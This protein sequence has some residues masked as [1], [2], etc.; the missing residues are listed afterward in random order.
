M[1]RYLFLV[2][3]LAA[4]GM[5]S[6][7][8]LPLKAPPYQSVFSTP[9]GVG[10]YGG[11]ITEADVAQAH[12]NGTNLFATSLVGG[13]LNATGGAVGATGGYIGAFPNGWW[14]VHNDVV[15][16]NV[17][18]TNA[19]GATAT[20]SAASAFVAQRWAAT[21]GLDVSMEWLQAIYSRLPA[22][23]VANFP[24]FVPPTL[25][26]ITNV[27]YGT[28]RNYAGFMLKEAGI[29]G[30]FGAARGTTIAVYP[31]LETGFIWPTINSLTGK[32]DGGALE[33]SAYVA[34]PI[35]GFTLNNAFSAAG[36]PTV[37][38]G[39]S[40]GT[41]YGARFSYLFGL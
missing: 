35:R 21:Q 2:P 28:P 30:G 17:A 26:T 29:S 24:T 37:G 25:P 40:L 22:L 20:T 36:L 41:N 34:F 9:N 1:R 15:W 23:P 39:A 7:A 10:W 12:A 11:I 19:V 33:A 27:T 18:G 32:P 13:G 8:D 5:S 38:A 31:G 14:R 6:A 4:T 16:S 3:L